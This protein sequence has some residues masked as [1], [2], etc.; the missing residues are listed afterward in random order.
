M[1]HPLRA[2]GAGLIVAVIAL[3]LMA[4][5]PSVAAHHSTT[6]FDYSRQLTIDGTVK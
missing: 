4:G 1:K 6:M 2:A 3:G 5:I